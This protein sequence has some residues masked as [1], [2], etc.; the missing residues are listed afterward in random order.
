MDESTTLAAGRKSALLVY[1]YA[2]IMEEPM[3]LD[4]HVLH[5][6][7]TGVHLAEAIE[8][9]MTRPGFLSTD[10]FKAFVKL[11]ASDHASNVPACVER[12]FSYMT[13]MDS[14]ARR[15]RLKE[16]HF[17]ANFMA[18]LHRPWIKAQLQSAL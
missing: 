5:K 14:N 1:V 11:G 12:G 15:R 10:E 6:S 8:A 9:V 17:R 16:P 2:P 18:H 4:V 13:G 7:A 3:A